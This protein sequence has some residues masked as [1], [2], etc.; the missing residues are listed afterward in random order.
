ML[1]KT[2]NLWIKVGRNSKKSYTILHDLAQIGKINE[3]NPKDV[4][5]LLVNL[6]KCIVMYCSNL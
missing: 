5:V 3:K 4:K 6:Y 2:T 1:Q